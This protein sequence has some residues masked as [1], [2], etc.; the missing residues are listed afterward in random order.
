MDNSQF[1]CPVCGSI[2]A[3]DDVFCSHCGTKL[4]RVVAIGWVRQI[5]IYFVSFFLPPFGLIWTW[6]YLRSDKPPLKRIGWISLLLTVVSIILTAWVT[7]GF[8][9]GV[10]SQINSVS[11]YS[12]L[13]L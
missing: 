5:W 8:F 2:T 11:N 10:S 9:Q 12:N 6:K 1:V 4:N 13:G 3:P 7:V